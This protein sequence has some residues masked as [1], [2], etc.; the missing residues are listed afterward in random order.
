[1]R[2]VKTREGYEIWDRICALPRYGFVHSPDNSRVL[3]VEGIGSWI[4]MYEA[5]RIVDDAQGEVNVLRA[6]LIKIIAL[7]DDIEVCERAADALID[8]RK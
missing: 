6:A 2:N 8:S 7:S 1:M 4:D 5:Q 3:K